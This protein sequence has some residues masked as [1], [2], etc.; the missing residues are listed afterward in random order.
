MDQS[1][2]PPAPS[3]DVAA[4]FLNAQGPAPTPPPPAPK[5]NKRPLIVTIIGA[6]LLAVSLG[7]VLLIVTANSTKAC[8]TA[9]DYKAL[10]GTSVDSASLS[11]TTNFYT[12]SIAFKAGAATYDNTAELIKQVT[13][14]YKNHS[15]SSV[16]ITVSGTYASNDALLLTEQRIDTIKASLTADG[17]PESVI[18]MRVP[19]LVVPEEDAP[20]DPS[21][22][23]ISITS[24][25][26]CS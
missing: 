13:D 5:K 14:F 21:S 7:I 26:K 6:G 25:E 23:F 16:V 1:T 9:A 22:A 24:N 4:W 18:K 17:V 15:G 3:A 10:T 20:A 11:P 2:N 8:L 12:A 19:E